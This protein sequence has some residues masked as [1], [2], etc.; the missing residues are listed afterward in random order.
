MFPPPPAS[1]QL[2]APSPPQLVASSTPQLVA[3]S[4]T[5]FPGPSLSTE[6]CNTHNCN[7]F[8]DFIFS[9]SILL[10]AILAIGIHVHVI[11]AGIINSIILR[12]IRS[13]VTEVTGRFRRG[14][15]RR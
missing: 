10:C 11:L 1:P 15:S 4:T 12:V 8:M 3:S 13:P 6:P 2:V 14:A 5:W 9:F 7:R